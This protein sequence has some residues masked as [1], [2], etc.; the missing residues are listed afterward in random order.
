[1]TAQMSREEVLAL[2]PTTDLVTLGRALGVSE[3]TIRE[4][5]RRGDLAKQG[6]RVVRAGRKLRVVTADLWALLGLNTN[7]PPADGMS[8]GA[9]KRSSRRPDQRGGTPVTSQPYQTQLHQSV[10][11]AEL[12]RWKCPD[13]DS[14][15]WAEIG[16]LGLPVV[17]RAHDET[18][19]AWNAT[20]RQAGKNPGDIRLWTVRLGGNR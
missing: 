16:P 13:C 10:Q 19:P 9:D 14:W 2:G 5:H 17:K 15:T 20:A 3:P 4:A 18:C 8:P 12:L 11:I 7:L 1:M 6:V